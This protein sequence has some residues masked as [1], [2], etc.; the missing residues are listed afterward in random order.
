MYDVR[1]YLPTDRRTFPP[2]TLLGQLGGVDLTIDRIYIRS[3]AMW[4]KKLGTIKQQQQQ[5]LLLLLLLLLSVLLNWSSFPALLQLAEPLQTAF[6][7]PHN[8]SITQY[9]SIKALYEQRSKKLHNRADNKGRTRPYDRD[10]LYH[11]WLYQALTVNDIFY[12]LCKLGINE[13]FQVEYSIQRWRH[14]SFCLTALLK[15]LQIGG[16]HGPAKINYHV[17]WTRRMLWIVV[18]GRSW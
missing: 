3:T 16:V 9:N 6:Y 2:L 17:I 1:R 12:Y 5:W 13:V 4:P 7:R 15:Q 18:D 11:S 14:R 10:D 8:L